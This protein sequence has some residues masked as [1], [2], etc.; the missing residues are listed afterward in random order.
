M[1][2]IGEQ[3]TAKTVMINGYTGKYN[4]EFHIAQSV[5]FS[6]A[7]TP[8]MFQVQLLFMGHS[9]TIRFIIISLLMIL[10][11]HFPVKISLS[12]F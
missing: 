1:L 6:S 4:T 3:G 5:N 8:Q 9:G 2:L 11:F 10:S 12:N 7:T